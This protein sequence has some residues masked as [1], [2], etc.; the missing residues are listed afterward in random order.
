M[1]AYHWVPCGS[2][3]GMKLKS[4]RHALL[5]QLST[6]MCHIESDVYGCFWRLQARHS[7]YA[8]MLSRMLRPVVRLVRLADTDLRL[9]T[10]FLGLDRVAMAPRLVGGSYSPISRTK[11]QYRWQFRGLYGGRW[12]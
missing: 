9:V 11:K 10:E 12:L 4:S 2:H 3:V 6:P 7:F 5:L 8:V 1:E